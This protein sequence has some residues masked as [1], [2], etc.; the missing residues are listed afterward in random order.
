VRARIYCAQI[1]AVDRAI[2]RVRKALDELQLANHTIL[3]FH[4]DNGARRDIVSTS[5]LPLAGYK[6]GC[7]EGEHAWYMHM[8]MHMVHVHVHM[9]VHM[10]M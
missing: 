2:D 3:L 7:W 5:N 6:G 9:C 8:Y 1:L 10:H 4:S